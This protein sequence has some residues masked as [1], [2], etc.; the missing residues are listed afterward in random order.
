MT[1][2]SLSEQFD[3]A[4]GLELSARDLT[5]SY[6]ALLT[7]NMRRNSVVPAAWGETSA[8]SIPA[9]CISGYT[10]TGTYSSATY[11]SWPSA[12]ASISG[13]TTTG[14][15]ASSATISVTTTNTACTT[16]TS[17]V[18]TFDLIATTVYGENI[19]L[20]GSIEQLGDWDPD[21]AI[22]L[23]ASEYTESDNLWHVT[24]DL[25]AG[26]TFEYKYIRVESDESVE[27]ETTS[28][29]V[30]TVPSACDATAATESDIWS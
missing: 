6:A 19:K 10:S 15:T 30:Y 7:A 18:V 27:W 21:D 23:S 9:T 12:L 20:S 29:R 24:V 25:P 8:S 22:A 26:T 3:K 2:G 17:V 4:D 14:S 5:W 1:N 13:S 16:P 11:T 28:N